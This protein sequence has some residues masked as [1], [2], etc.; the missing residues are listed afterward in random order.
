MRET[1]EIIVSEDLPW[2]NRNAPHPGHRE[3]ERIMATCEDNPRGNHPK[4]VVAAKLAMEK[5]VAE[6]GGRV[7][8]LNPTKTED[9][10]PGFLAVVEGYKPLPRQRP[11]AR[12]GVHAP[13]ANRLVKGR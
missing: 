7:R 5:W 11:V 3:I 12:A 10:S 1:I 13:A 2:V 8:A 4:R 6:N 9:G